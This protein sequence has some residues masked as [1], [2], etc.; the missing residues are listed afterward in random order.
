MLDRSEGGLAPT[1]WC[2]I[3]ALAL[4]GAA[5]FVNTWIGV[6]VLAVAGTTF[7]VGCV[8]EGRTAQHR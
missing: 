7:V 6:A 2:G 5:F 3:V 1:T 4:A 8:R